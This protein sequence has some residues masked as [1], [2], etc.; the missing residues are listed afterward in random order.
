MKALRKESPIA[1]VELPAT[2]FGELDGRVVPD[3]YSMIKLPGRAVHALDAVARDSGYENTSVVI[4]LQNPRGEM[5]S[6][7]RNALER[8]EVIFLSSITRTAKQTMALGRKLKS[9]GKI[10][11]AGG[12]D[13]AFR[14]EE[15]LERGSVDYVVI[16][17]GEPT[18]RDMLPLIGD[19]EALEGVSGLA[20]MSGGEV[21]RTP[22]REYLT[23]AELGMLPHPRY[24]DAIRKKSM[25]G[26]METSRGCPNRCPFCGVSVFYGGKF[27]HKPIDYVIDGLK[28]I[29]GMGRSVFFTDDNFPANQRRTIRLLEAILESNALPGGGSAQA[30]VKLAENE[31]LMDLMLRAGIDVVYIGL[32]SLVDESLESLGKPYSSAENKEAIKIIRKKGFWIHGMFMP[33]G[34]GDTKERL[35]E[36]S[37]YINQ[38]IDSAQFFSPITIPGT[39]FE[40]EMKDAGRILVDVKEKPYLYDGQ[41]VLVMPKHFEPYDLQ[42]AINRMYESFY[43]FGNCVRRMRGCSNKKL[44]LGILFYTQVMGGLRKGL[45]NEQ[46]RAHMNFLRNFS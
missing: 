39:V 45:Y 3:I 19:N 32:E 8:S 5:S 38:N 12:P 30:T 36:S 43:S 1:F 14:A 26:V 44:A 6:E 41:N 33:G 11:V 28:Q 22:E 35:L 40:S 20:F 37:Q 21:F 25:V 34:D 24:D 7:D 18:F 27:R 23:E 2:Q 16:K 4:P 42:M 9:A 31:R 17:E 13:P 29:K 46:T 15:Y 10:V